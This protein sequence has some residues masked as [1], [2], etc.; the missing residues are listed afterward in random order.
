MITLRN[1]AKTLGISKPVLSKAITRGHLSAAKRDDGSLAID[2]SELSRWWESA[3]HRFQAATTGDSQPPTD[4]DGGNFPA[5]TNAVHE[6][7]VRIVEAEVKALRELLEAE[8]RR[9]DEWQ[10]KAAQWEEQAQRLLMA[11]PIVTPPP[12][13]PAEPHRF[14]WRW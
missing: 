8:R 14:R 11:A 7:H 12:P 1:A 3:G 9:S 5:N 4:A 6:L 10:T 13:T 2:P